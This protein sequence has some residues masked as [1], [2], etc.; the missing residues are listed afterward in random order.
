MIYRLPLK[1][2]DKTAL[3]SGKVYDHITNN[4]YFKSIDFLKHLRIHSYGYAFYQKNYPKPGG[5]YKNVTIYLHRYIAENFVEKPESEKRLLVTFKNGNRL[6]CREENIIW[7]T[8]SQIIRNI[9]AVMNTTTGFRGVSKANKK[10][11][12]AIFKGKNRHDLGGFD[13]P[14]EAALA[15]NIKSREWFGETRSLNKLPEDLVEQIKA[16]WEK[17]GKTI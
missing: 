5:G 11:R 15:Y 7:A 13:T 4:D 2:T 12:A 17:A 10:Y 3:V 1:N 9:S 8:S 16:K 14:E 6:D